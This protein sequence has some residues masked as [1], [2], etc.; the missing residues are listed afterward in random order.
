M[1]HLDEDFNPNPYIYN[2]SS[3]IK[4]LLDWEIEKHFLCKHGIFSISFI[5]TLLS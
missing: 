2:E 1:D 5:C 4:K 3:L